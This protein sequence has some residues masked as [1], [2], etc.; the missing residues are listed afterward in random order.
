MS[1]VDDKSWR[2]LVALQEDARA[3]LK[4]L[5][6]IAGLSVPATAER[7]KKMEDA[8]II[9]GYHA[10]IAPETVGRGFDVVVHAELMLKDRE[11][12]EAFEE[13]VAAMDEVVECR[14]LFG[15][16]DYL[17]RIAVA[18]AEA[19]E[20]FYISRLAELPGLQ[21]VNSQITMKV[22]KALGRSQSPVG[23]SRP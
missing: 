9:R 5:A 14:R 21:R 7:I 23:P 10:D 4:T 18:D 13:Q 6:E 20:A 15:V 22:V 16:P 2:I 3:S 1:P 8:G 19:Y 11:T 17:I 12:V